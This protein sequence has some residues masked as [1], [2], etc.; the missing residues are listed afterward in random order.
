MH[1]IWKDIE[2]YEG[3][4]QVSNCGRVKSVFRIIIRRNGTPFS[5]NEIILKPSKSQD[6]YLCVSMRKNFKAKGTSIHRLVAQAF[7]SNPLKLPEINHKDENKE[8]NKMDNLE[9]CTRSYNTSY[10]TFQERRKRNTDW[11][12]I[13]QKRNY[14]DISLKRSLK[15]QLAVMQYDLQGNLIKEY[16]SVSSAAKTLGLKC[17]ENIRHSCSGTSKSAYGFVWKYK[18]NVDI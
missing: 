17:S 18:K 9:W 16:I 7:I 3:Y 1:E 10:G 4:Y 5:V 6:G 13:A 14:K 11:K 15:I 2:G 12:K 8:N